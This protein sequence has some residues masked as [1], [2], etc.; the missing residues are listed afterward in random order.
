MSHWRDM[1]PHPH[2]CT[3][4]LMTGR[5]G[6]YWQNVPFTSRNMAHKSYVSSYPHVTKHTSAAPH[7]PDSN[8]SRNGHRR[9][10]VACSDT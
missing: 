8:S 1:T 3:H 5:C 10:R 9:L 4:L 7:K 2:L 6:M